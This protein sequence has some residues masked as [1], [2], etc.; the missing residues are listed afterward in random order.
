M[1]ST[2]EDAYA[3]TFASGVS[4][5]LSSRHRELVLR[6]SGSDPQ[7]GDHERA[8]RR[9]HLTAHC[10]LQGPHRGRTRGRAGDG[11]RTTWSSWWAVP[12]AAPMVRSPSRACSRRRR[13]GH[14]SRRVWPSARHSPR[15]LRAPSARARSHRSTSAPMTSRVTHWAWSCS[16]TAN[17]ATRRSFVATR[18]F[19]A[20]GP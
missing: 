16:R 15:R 14:Q 11:V 12:R 4:A 2:R 3:M 1:V 17:C 13:D 10:T 8:L 9:P 6:L 20:S 7:R 5:K 18:G 19:R